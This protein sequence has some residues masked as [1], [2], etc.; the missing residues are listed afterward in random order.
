MTS[1]AARLMPLA[2]TIRGGKGRFRSAERTLAH[3]ARLRRNPASSTPPHSILTKV[4]ITSRTVAGWQVYTVSPRGGQ[5]RRHALYLHG[6]SYVYEIAPQHWTLIADLAVRAGLTFTV[7]IL[8]LAPAETASTM[9][10]KATD[11][12][13]ALVDEYGAE[14]VSLFGDSAGGGMALAVA[15]LLRDRGIPSP[16]ATVLISP[17][18]DVSC[19]DPR[20]VELDPRDPWL[21]VPGSKAAG[22]LYRGE[23]RDTDPLVSPIYGSLDELGPVTVFTGT[24]DILNADAHRLATMAAD[25]GLALDFHEVAGMIHNYPL[26]PIP[27]ARTARQ[28]MVQAVVS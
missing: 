7:P 1:L 18:L 11:L 20:L 27:E 10:P 17:W 22:D 12:A 3:V 8:P 4:D 14:Q 19:S 2:I 28:I 15:Q 23:L 16:H 9:V 5:S 21:A 26:L 6:G 24:R 25:A 13:A